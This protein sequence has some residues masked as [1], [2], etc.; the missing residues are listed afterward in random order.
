MAKISLT[1][2]QNMQVGR[3][4][5]WS[6]VWHVW[7]NLSASLAVGDTDLPALLEPEEPD[8]WPTDGGP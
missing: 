4:V 1:S 3:L 8:F 5:I 7:M 2:A 6:V